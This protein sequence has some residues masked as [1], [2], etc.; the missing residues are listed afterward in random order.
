[1]VAHPLCRIISV[2]L[3]VQCF[4]A[5]STNAAVHTGHH[6]SGHKGPRYATTS[7]AMSVAMAEN[8]VEAK[9]SKPKPIHNGGG[10]KHDS[11]VD[12]QHPTTVVVSTSKAGKPAAPSPSPP[13]DNSWHAPVTHAP[14]SNSWEGHS[15]ATD[16]KTAKA[17]DAKKKTK[18]KSSS[19]SLGAKTHKDA[20][21]S[22]SKADK[23][24]ET[25]A[26]KPAPNEY[27]GVKMVVKAP[28]GATK[29]AKSG[30]V[31]TDDGSWS[32]GSSTTTTTTSTMP[33]TTTQADI[34]SVATLPAQT[35][36]PATTTE[37]VQRAPPAPEKKRDADEDEDEDAMPTYSPTSLIKERAS[38]EETFTAMEPFGLRF[39]SSK[40][41]PIFDLDTVTTVTMEHLLHSFRTKGWDVNRLKLM[42]LD[43]EDEARIRGLRKLQRSF[44][45]HELVFGGILYFKTTSEMP[46]EDE[47]TF[48]TEESF[49]GDRLSYFVDLLQEKGM[50]VSSASWGHLA[51]SSEPIQDGG[52]VNLVL[53]LGVTLGSIGLF[54]ACLLSVRLF[55]KRQRRIEAASSRPSLVFRIKDE[56]DMVDLNG[57]HHEA[58]TIPSTI[59]DNAASSRY[60]YYTKQALTAEA[61]DPVSPL[62]TPSDTVST[63]TRYVS[64]FTVK[65][66]CGG[67]PLEQVD[68]RKLAVAYLS[69]LFKKVPHTILLP[70]DKDSDLPAITSIR[71]IPDDLQELLAY[72]G[73]PRIDE[74]TGKVLFNLRCESDIPMSKMKNLSGQKKQKKS[75]ATS[76]DYS[77][78]SGFEDVAL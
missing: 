74:Y 75:T 9:A 70:Y 52:K 71:N 41:Q 65:K 50:D 11:G 58:S 56:V 27:N 37:A 66:D 3:I 5:T 61:S 28:E 55:N 76:D 32:S 16:S 57:H 39:L 23:G 73:Q 43:E 60:S 59:E 34:P 77:A 29:E 54:I 69:R 49:T 38:V 68:L 47:M 21:T 33:A 78:S 31:E 48:I 62:E 10:G 72:V 30:K 12:G 24:G 17:S 64:V 22:D 19:M 13:A 18:T 42:L 20:A 46:S 2:A 45:V 63:S 1:M 15:T 44:P 7:S 67:K 25:K 53:I 35:T 26:D 6:P 8:E 51:T 40:A 14:T 4:I 36:P